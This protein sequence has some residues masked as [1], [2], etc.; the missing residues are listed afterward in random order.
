MPRVRTL[1]K[2]LA[3]KLYLDTHFTVR[4][5][6]ETYRT[7]SKLV[8]VNENSHPSELIVV[9]ALYEKGLLRKDVERF[10]SALKKKGAMVIAANTS[11]L[12][13]EEAERIS[14]LI[15]VYIERDNLGRDFGSYKDCFNYLYKEN[16]HQQCQRLIMCNDSVYYCTDGLDEFIDEMVSTKKNVLGATENHDIERHLGSFFISLSSAIINNKKFI[17]YWS[18]YKK[19]NIRPKIIKT[20]E[21]GL[22]KVLKSISLGDDDCVALY[23]AQYI[24][25]WASD[26]PRLVELIRSMRDGDDF[27]G[28]AVSL[29]KRF[30]QN[31]VIDSYFRKYMKG[32]LILKNKDYYH[33]EEYYQDEIETGA[34]FLSFMQWL[35][36]LKMPGSEPTKELLNA[37]K[38]VCIEL[39][40]QG[41]QIH[42]N[43]L[44]FKKLG[45]P[46]IKLDLLYR[47]AY[48][49]YDIIRITESIT[50]PQE[51]EEFKKMIAARLAGKNFHFG[52]KKLAFKHGYI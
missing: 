11:S 39:L 16:L 12:V 1:S 46:I 29:N 38:S 49:M 28:S 5:L 2:N 40:T 18:D 41:S 32:I 47:C 15:D 50:D 23:N 43:G 45:L 35:D 52:F 37:L 27:S 9:M 48:S 51:A 25:K 20:G 3:V 44:I 17:Q 34:H 8:V 7:K 31:V 4:S 36:Y 21:L 24:D 13:R 22:S 30:C 14:Q 19:T 33:N 6:S 26:T 42:L 10:L